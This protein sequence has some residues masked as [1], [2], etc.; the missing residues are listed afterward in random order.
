MCVSSKVPL[1]AQYLEGS[2][3]SRQEQQIVTAGIATKNN[4]QSN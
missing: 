4:G 1:M 3:R 2:G